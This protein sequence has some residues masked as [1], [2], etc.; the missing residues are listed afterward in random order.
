MSATSLCVALSAMLAAW[1]TSVRNHRRSVRRTEARWI[2]AGGIAAAAQHWLATPAEWGGSADDTFAGVTPD[3]L[4]LAPSIADRRAYQTAS[5][6]YR[7]F[8]IAPRRWAAAWTATH[9]HTD[10]P[11]LI[12]VGTGDR[13][14]EPVA[15]LAVGRLFIRRLPRVPIQLVRAIAQPP[16]AVMADPSMPSAPTPALR[17]ARRLALR[18]VR[19][20]RTTRP[21]TQRLPVRH[22]LARYGHHPARSYPRS[23]SQR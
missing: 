23:D 22:P 18:S 11:G 16:P 6:C 20:R 19:H 12:V 21:S 13:S 5:G 1:G 4:G 8:P 15:V 10:A 3:R 9:G 7:L 14:E 17:S 2:E